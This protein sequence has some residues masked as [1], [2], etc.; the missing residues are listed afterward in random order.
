[1]RMVCACAEFAPDVALVDVGLPGGSGIDLIRHARR[2]VPRCEVMVVTV[3]ADEQV[4]F[5]CIEAGATGYLLKESSGVDIVTQ[6]RML[7]EGGS[8]I[9]PSVARQLLTRMAPRAEVSPLARMPDVVL[10]QPGAG[11]SATL[12]Q[13]LQLR[14]DRP[15]LNL[16]RHTVET[17]VKRTYRKLQVH[18][19]T[20]AVYEGRKL[21]FVA[22]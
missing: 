5:Q 6:I 12:R 1:M 7:L 15:L 19:K 22:D 20:E 16:S 17:Y 4:V 13:G 8:P 3:F 21:G 10:L 11:R 14:G 18:S 9:T 2:Y